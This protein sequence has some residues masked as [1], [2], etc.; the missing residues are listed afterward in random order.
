MGRTMKQIT[1]D[2]SQVL[3]EAEVEKFVQ[4]IAGDGRF[5]GKKILAIIPDDTRTAPIDLLFRL[6]C[7]HLLPA[8][9]QIDFLI[10][11]GTHPPLSPERIDRLVGMDECERNNLFPGVNVFNHRWDVEG[12][13]A[14][15]GK[16]TP[17][18]VSE[19]SEGMITDEI[20][21]LLNRMIGDYDLLL[22]VGPTFPHEVIGFSGGNKYF[23]PGISGGDVINV[24][25]WLGALHTIPKIIGRKDTPVRHVVDRAVSF[26]PCQRLCISLVVTGDGL[27]G[28]FFGTPEEAFDKAADLSADYHIV[29][30]NRLYH[31]VIACAPPMYEDLWTAGKC[32]Y[33][34]MNVIEPSGKLIIYAPHI[35]DISHTHGELIRK[36][37]YHVKDYFLQQWD[38]FK[39][40][41]G[42][43]LAHSTHVK[44][45]GRYE[46]GKEY[47][48]VE[49]IL[50]TGISEQICKEINLGFLS[51]DSIRIEDYE[52]REDEGVL[53]VRKAGEYLYLEAR[54][55][56]SENRGRIG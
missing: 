6:L 7:T 36:V 24:T 27:K 46:D 25:H 49:V 21:V 26:I 13:L 32:M 34:L 15:F 14:E 40:S 43:I 29:F 1:S 54:G 56:K 16:I 53:C 28:M 35:A 2:K 22:V 31:T 44:G 23:F 19:L 12:T 18:E 20:C 52:N 39:D 10:A 17:E 50:A 3:S 5:C 38:R 8:A 33:K 51:P 30:K 11:L 4:E 47:P 55:E 42:C 9:K 48:D 37:G 45:L 41:P